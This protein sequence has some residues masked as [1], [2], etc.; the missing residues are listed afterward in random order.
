VPG[1]RLA[2]SI[3]RKHS[4]IRHRSKIVLNDLQRL[5]IHDILKQFQRVP[6]ESLHYHSNYI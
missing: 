1:H 6:H 4:H 3:D 2:A 5:C